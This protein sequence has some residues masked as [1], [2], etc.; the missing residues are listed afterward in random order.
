VKEDVAMMK[1]FSLA[2]DREIGKLVNIGKLV[3]VDA[4]I[5]QIYLWKDK[6]VNWK[7]MGNLEESRWYA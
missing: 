1:L 4:K 5:L 7:P 3:F 6:G 2:M